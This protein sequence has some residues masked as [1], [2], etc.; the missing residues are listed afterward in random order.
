MGVGIVGVDHVGGGEDT[1]RSSSRKGRIPPV[2][3][4]VEASEDTQ[5]RPAAPPATPTHRR[6]TALVK[7]VN[8][9]PHINR[10]L[11]A[12]DSLYWQENKESSLGE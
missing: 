6:D 3:V 8:T 1:R 5:M 2:T 11:Q 10:L 9:L 7:Q 12:S 4:K